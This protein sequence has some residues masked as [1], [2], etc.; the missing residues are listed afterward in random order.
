MRF[1]VP[2]EAAS[3][4]PSPP[5]MTPSVRAMVDSMKAVKTPVGAAST[6][7]ARSSVQS[8]AASSR[9]MMKLKPVASVNTRGL[10][11]SLGGASESAWSR[12]LAPGSRAKPRGGRTRLSPRD[13][14]SRMA[15]SMPLSAMS[16]P[17]PAHT[18]PRASPS[19]L[20]VPRARRSATMSAV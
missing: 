19:Q 6:P 5:G 11:A 2:M 8:V 18:N 16:T 7:R 14:R 17:V 20:A 3:N 1:S 15:M 13:R 4:V 10:C 12:V 9:W